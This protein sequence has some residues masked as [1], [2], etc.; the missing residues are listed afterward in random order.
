MDRKRWL[1]MYRAPNESTPEDSS[2]SL[3]S[4][5]AFR[6]I[7]SEFMSYFKPGEIIVDVNCS[8]YALWKKL[9]ESNTKIVGLLLED[10]NEVVKSNKKGVC[11]VLLEKTAMGY[12]GTFNGFLCINVMNTCTPESTLNLIGWLYRALKHSAKGLVVAETSEAER[13]SKTVNAMK[14][15]GIPAFIGEFIEAGVYHFKPPE[16]VLRGL[17]IGAGFEVLKVVSKNN[18]LYMLLRK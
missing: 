13:A 5:T 12:V 8:A 17:F 2:N 9:I 3:L 16:N 7:F 10:S 14:S 6:G 11:K 4:D 1:D 18:K 15:R